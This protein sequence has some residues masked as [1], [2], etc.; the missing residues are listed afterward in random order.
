MSKK[1]PDPITQMLAMVQNL[2]LSDVYHYGSLVRDAIDRRQR[3]WWGS[4]EQK[5]ENEARNAKNTARK[6]SQAKLTAKRLKWV[7][8]NLTPGMVVKMSG[9]RDGH[10]VRY[11]TDIA[12]GTVLCRQMM[13]THRMG[14]SLDEMNAAY[15]NKTWMKMAI[16]S[17]PSSYSIWE[18]M[19]AGTD[20]GLDKVVGVFTPNEN[21]VLEYKAIK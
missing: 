8:A 21:G 13:P 10:G 16:P 5:A 19:N 20:H 1:I 7:E 15:P 11:V 9:T 3:S 2:P 17:N 18:V 4:D 6:V 14:R 12:R